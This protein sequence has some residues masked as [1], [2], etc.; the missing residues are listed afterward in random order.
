MS[1]GSYSLQGG[2]RTNKLT[3]EGIRLLRQNTN[4]YSISL[5]CFFTNLPAGILSE[6]AT[7]PHITQVRLV[8]VEPPAADYAAL[9]AMTN[10]TDFQIYFGLNFADDELARFTN[11]PSLKNLIVQSRS[12]SSNSAA[13]LPQFRSL[14]NLELESWTWK[15]NWHSEVDGAQQR[16]ERK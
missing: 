8:G 16:L 11:A 2:G 13:L 7:L 3:A 1:C 6:V 12:L 5:A 9:A 15:T 4:L 14:T 10:L